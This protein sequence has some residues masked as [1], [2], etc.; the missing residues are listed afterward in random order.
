LDKHARILI[1]ADDESERATL[2]AILESE[3]YLVDYAFNGKEAIKN[4][5]DNLQLGRFWILDILNLRLKTKNL[6]LAIVAKGKF[7]TKNYFRR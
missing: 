3:G 1:V 7:L 2:K 6:I 5:R 4:S